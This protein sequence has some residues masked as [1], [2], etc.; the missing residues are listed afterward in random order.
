MY[1][2]EHKHERQPIKNER[3]LLHYD[4]GKISLLLD[5]LAVSSVYLVP[6]LNFWYKFSGTI[7]TAEYGFIPYCIGI[8]K[9]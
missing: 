5:R 6:D 2:T 4:M 8:G 9:E 1:Y 3:G 7:S